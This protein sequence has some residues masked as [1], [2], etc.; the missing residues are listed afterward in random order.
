MIDMASYGILGAIL[1]VTLILARVIEA[2]VK[3]FLNLGAWKTKKESP[4]E[5]VSSLTPE[6]ANELHQAYTYNLEQKLQWDYVRDEL[7]EQSE[8]C[9]DLHDAMRD[10]VNTQ[11]RS[12]DNTDRLV[13]RIDKLL[14]RG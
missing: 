9:N 12:C 8:N 3:K 1:G 7:K 14:D 4:S 2:L 10:L 6:Q 11:Q 13:S 5:I